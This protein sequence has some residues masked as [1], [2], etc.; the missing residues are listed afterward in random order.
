MVEKKS[1]SISH[2]W[3]CR[4]RR[5]LLREYKFLSDQYHVLPHSAFGANVI[6]CAK[7]KKQQRYRCHT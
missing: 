4:V 7:G 3:N 5:D 6:N 2:F 1:K